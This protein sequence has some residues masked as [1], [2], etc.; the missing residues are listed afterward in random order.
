VKKLKVVTIALA[1]CSM[2]FAASLPKRPVNSQPEKEA[3]ARQQ[4]QDALQAA[5]LS[6]LATTNCAFTFVGGTNNNSMDFCV[7]VNGNIAEL[8]APGGHPL[9]SVLDRSEGYAI[10]DV[11][12]GDPQGN[13]RVAYSDFAAF[14]DTGNWNSPVVSQSASGAVKVVRITSDGIWTLTQTITSLAPSPALK[15]VMGLKN[16]TA[17]TREAFLVRWADVDADDFVLNNFDGTFSNAIGWNSISSQSATPVG[18]L[19]ENLGTLPFGTGSEAFGQNTFAPPNPCNPGLNFVA[20]PI[21]STDGSV[22]L[23]YDLHVDKKQTFTVT[24]GYKGL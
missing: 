16:N 3:A 9:V 8:S 10:C 22:V 6:P 21:L 4:K 19:L 7:T 1:L 5:V 24:L 17:V 2:S 12:N 18:L 20:S 11:T 13:G 14:G 15:I 23:L